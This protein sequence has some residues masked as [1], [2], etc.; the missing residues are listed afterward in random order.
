MTCSRRTAEKTI[1]P[2]ELGSDEVS[3]AG[4]RMSKVMVDQENG[5]DAQ[6]RVRLLI[7][8]LAM[9]WGGG[10]ASPGER[11]LREAL[12]A[13]SLRSAR[14]ECGFGLSAR[15]VWELVVRHDLLPLAEAD[16][17]Y[18]VVKGDGLLVPRPDAARAFVRTLGARTGW[19]AMLERLWSHCTAL[20]I[21]ARL[22]AQGA[23]D[24]AST[25]RSDAPE[26]AACVSS[27]R[28]AGQAPR[29]PL[30]GNPEAA[31]GGAHAH[32]A[33]V[34]AHQLFALLQVAGVSC[35]IALAAGPNEVRAVLDELACFDE[36]ARSALAPGAPG[37]A[38]A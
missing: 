14:A 38:P 32:G 37:L 20:A 8:K 7:E 35:Q 2:R 22:E 33:L 9:L 3:W 28:G 27:E 10:K 29:A 4:R 12:D 30:R 26:D 13:C 21:S 19:P 34:R 16:I 15:R 36:I 25:T 17:A 5:V 31:L 18:H 23:A 6:G 11:A 24:E 1:A